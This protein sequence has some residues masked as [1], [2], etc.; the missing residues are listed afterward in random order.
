M[1]FVT[2]ASGFIGKHLLDVLTQRG[3]TIHCLVLPRSVNDFKDLIEDRWPDAKD[4]FVV[5]GGDIG[6]SLCGLQQSKV[7]EL[8]E[9]IV[10][11]FHLAALYDMTAGMQESER[12]NVLGTRNACR[13]AEELDATLHYV[14]STAV[15]GN[16]V[17]FFRED[18]F[19]EGQK[20]K[21]AYFKTK[22]LAEKLVRDECQTRYK[23]YRP[24]AVVGSTHPNRER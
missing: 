13:L 1:Y 5:H 14:S 3:K 2:G 20:H 19:D 24:G 9:E 17:G 7:D 4:L 11:M 21:N 22:F 18:M 8:R 10:H 23:I 16:Y 15:A 6:K 12:A